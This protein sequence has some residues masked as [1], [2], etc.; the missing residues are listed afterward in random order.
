[1]DDETPQVLTA[2]PKGYNAANGNRDWEQ[3]VRNNARYVSSK[4]QIASSGYHTF[5]VWMVDPGVVL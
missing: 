2:V 3:A 5:N 1:M 4:H